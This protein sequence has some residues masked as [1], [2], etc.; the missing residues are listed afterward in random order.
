M[1]LIKV[2]I[3][4]Y[5][6]IHDSTEFDIDDITCLVGKNES[7]KTAI[8][9]TLHK[10][11][12]FDPTDPASTKFDR[13]NDNPVENPQSHISE[14]DVV[15]ATFS[16]EQ[17]DIE[18]IEKFITCKCINSSNPTITLSRG[19]SDTI[20]VVKYGFE[21]DL[22]AII[23]HI[24]ATTK[25][26]A[27]SSMKDPTKLAKELLTK[28]NPSENAPYY[29][30]LENIASSNLLDYIFSSLLRARIP[31]FIYLDQ[32]PQMS[33]VIEISGLFSRIQ[34]S[35]TTPVDQPIVEILNLAKVNY[36]VLINAQNDNE[37]GIEIK[38]AENALNKEL[39]KILASWSQHKIYT[40]E[41]EILSSG[42]IGNLILH[43]YIE[44]R[45]NAEGY[46]TRKPFGFESQGFRWFFSFLMMQKHFYTD[47]N[48]VIFLLDEPGLSLHAKAQKDLLQFFEDDLASRHQV[49]YTTHSPFMIDLGHLNRVRTVE[50]KSLEEESDQ[51]T[52]SE[53]GTKVS[54][55][56]H[57]AGKDTLI[58][59]QSALGYD[60]SQG[61]FTGRNYL[62]VEGKSDEI[63]IR[64][65]SSLL[66]KKGKQGLGPWNIV[67]TGGI[68]KV[69]SFVKLF[70]ATGLDIAVLVDRHHNERQ[71]IENLS[72]GGAIDK[73]RVLTYADFTKKNESDVEDML[74][75]D[76]YLKLV[77]GMYG[78]SIGRAN[79]PRHPRII[80][81]LERHFKNNPIPDDVSFSH[82]KPAEY[83]MKNI[84]LIEI[85][86][87]VLDR[88]QKLFDKLL[89]LSGQHL[90][91]VR[92]S[93]LE[94][95]FVRA[96][97]PSG[98]IAANGSITVTFDNA[99]ADV[100][101]S[102]GT[103]TVA[104]KTATIAGPF[105][106]GPL[107]L[108]ITWADG[109][110]ALNY[111]VTASD[112]TAPTV[113]GGTVKDGDKDVDPEAINTGSIQ[114]EFSE[115]VSGNVAL[116]TEGGDDVGWSGKVEGNKATLKLVKGKEIGN[117]TT[118]VIAGKV[119]DAAGN[120]TD[121]SVTFVTK[122]VAGGTIG[123]TYWNRIVRGTPNQEISET[124]QRHI[125]YW[126][127]LSEYMVEKGSSVNCP[128][129]RPRPSLD[130]R[131]GRT[132]FGIEMRLRSSH[133]EIGIWL[134]IQGDNAE[135]HFHLLEEQREGIHTEMGRKLKWI[136]RTEHKRKRIG[137][138]KGDT[139]L[140]DEN[141]W[142]HQYEWFAAR[143]ELFVYV[144]QE[145]I[146]RL[147][148]AD[149]DPS[150]KKNVQGY[151]IPPTTSDTG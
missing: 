118:Y 56:V 141:D 4:N 67:P 70:G 14:T 10:F 13:S 98:E 33:G 83:L 31:K 26:K 57:S 95:T 55:E 116:Q 129:P 140:L 22:E 78:I 75:L 71:Q 15:E 105:T 126:A 121:V 114:I 107:A 43:I 38:K 41:S 120:S 145:R 117:G 32:Y 63:Y 102:A 106:P 7:G 25:I 50:N 110:Q 35:K 40:M 130:L 111:T 135:A 49:I 5:K 37:R 79:L 150:K 144:F 52:Y 137:L 24:S 65:I 87:G 45:R 73:D 23:K 12:P 109:A 99:P 64:A 60:I 92:E 132:G 66:E 151:T 3:K 149:W 91:I 90:D 29:N 44:D 59:L 103:V 11:N 108:T 27:N 28:S 51:L 101:V 96:N 146:Q 143:L 115:E 80:G 104:G 100:T 85:P 128:S 147:D 84:E 139:D 9:E 124:E 54:P 113:T 136:E 30:I 97:P 6:C 1:K 2:R 58:P 134:Y 20:S 76:F 18:E 148:A 68:G 112:T 77:N 119:S 42:S 89:V 133:N 125:R 46:L 17:E 82:L 94:A 69:A 131:L 88:F 19:Y 62:I 122:G 39:N 16:L 53:S 142:P 123:K 47:N 8:L 61:V 93:E 127:G 81:R 138:D 48:D 86:E 34:E 36:D 74:T 21:V 72:N